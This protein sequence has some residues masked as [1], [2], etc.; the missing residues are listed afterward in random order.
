[1]AVPAKRSVKAR[2]NPD[3]HDALAFLRAIW[4]LDH[5]LQTRSKQMLRVLGVTGPQRFVI[6]LI[7]ANPSCAAGEIAETMQVHPSTLTGVLRRL[8]RHGLVDRVV[9]QSD[10]RRALFQLTAKGKVI[11][12]HRA[13][14]VESAV[15]RLQRRAKEAEILS[16]L[17][18]FAALTEELERDDA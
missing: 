13:G 11:D 18:I 10:R 15:R 17:R 6:R 1:M 8:E 14:T 3:A 7:G 5:S 12:A 4:A 9:D 2:A 16:T